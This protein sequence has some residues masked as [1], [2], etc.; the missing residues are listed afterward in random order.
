MVSSDCTRDSEHKMK[1]KRFCLIIREHIFTVRVTKDLNRL[2]R[3][4]VDCLS[5]DI[6]KS[7]LD[8]V[9]GNLL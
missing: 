7:C 9:L 8:M 5:L 3:E 2:P 1:H 4:V 6:F